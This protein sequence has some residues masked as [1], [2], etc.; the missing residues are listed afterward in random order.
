M[1]PVV[2]MTDSR[3][4]QHECLEIKHLPLIKIHYLNPRIPQSHYDWLIFTSKNAVQLFFEHFQDKVTFDHIAVIGEKTAEVIKKLGYRVDY[5]PSKY[6]QE[7]FIDE[8][9]TR[10]HNKTVLLPVSKLARPKLY[11]A[12]NAS[13]HLTKIDLYTSVPDDVNVDALYHLL[14]NN[15]ADAV[16]FM[17]PSAVDA[18]FQ[19]YRA[20]RSAK[21]VA[22][23]QIT[24]K[25]LQKYEQSHTVAKKETKNDMINMI[26]NFYKG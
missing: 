8:M 24:S 25:A 4:Y 5:M 14:S 21:V 16:T 1:K 26:L 15:K 12:L 17:S 18:Y 2:L 7:C 22:I 19:K 11:D 10:F 3:P 13:A 23:G 6:Q 9:G 20:I